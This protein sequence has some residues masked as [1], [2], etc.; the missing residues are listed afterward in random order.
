MDLFK[1]YATNE[2]LEVE[3][4][5]HQ[6]GPDDEDYILVARMGNDRFT[7]VF[8]RINTE[9]SPQVESEDAEV[10]KH[11]TTQVM[12]RTMAESIL[13][14]WGKTMTYQD[15]PLPYSVENAAKVLAHK[16]FRE[17]VFGLSRN[18][19]HYLLSKQAE[20]AKN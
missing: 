3:G 4:V 18:A 2:K 15:K 10:S 17:M 19:E 16:D 14:G 13:V 9:L 20:V 1:R 5:R 6:I 11:A 12:V 8:A 7:E